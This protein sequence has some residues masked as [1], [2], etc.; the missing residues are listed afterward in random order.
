MDTTQYITITKDE[1]EKLVRHTIRFE[2]LNS[3]FTRWADTDDMLRRED[4]MKR[5]RELND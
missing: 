2:L 4:A 3:L 1:Y 5:R